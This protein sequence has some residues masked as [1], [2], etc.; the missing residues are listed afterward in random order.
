[1]LSVLTANGLNYFIC[2]IFP[3]AEVYALSTSI[4]NFSGTL[5]ILKKLLTEDLS[6]ILIQY[7]V[8]SFSSI[9]FLSR[10]ALA[11]L[12]VEQGRICALANESCWIYLSES[13]LEIDIHKI[14]CM[15]P[16]NLFIYSVI[17]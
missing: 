14:K 17:K 7:E 15:R 13:N 16:F 8:K 2:I 11:F 3:G 12:L 9:V 10:L 4:A 5:L 6:L 1:M